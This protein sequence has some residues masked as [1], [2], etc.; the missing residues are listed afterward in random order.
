[1][2]RL[3]KKIGDVVVFPSELVGVTISPDNA[4]VGE[5]LKRLSAYED[6]ELE[7]E[8]VERVLDEY[9]RCHTLRASCAERL[10]IIR[11]IPTGQLQGLVRLLKSCTIAWP[12]W[13]SVD[14]ALPPQDGVYLVCTR[15]GAVTTAHFYPAYQLPSG[16]YKPHEW[17]SNRNVAYWMALPEPPEEVD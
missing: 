3:V 11:D 8:E 9:G 5:L 12:K 1:M 2:E 4:V 14:Q 10:D 13:I 17:Q 7:P 16:A 15:K 6:T